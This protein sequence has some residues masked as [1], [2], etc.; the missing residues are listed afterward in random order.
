MGEIHH[1]P[2]HKSKVRRRDFPGGP[3]VKTPRFHCRERRFNPWSGN[4]DPTCRAGCSQ[5]K[6]TKVRCQE[7]KLERRKVPRTRRALLSNWD[8]HL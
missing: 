8:C 4:Q 1:V 6:K 5:K 7:A 2:E 3:V